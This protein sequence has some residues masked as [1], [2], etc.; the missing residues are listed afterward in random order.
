VSKN[1]TLAI[2]E[3]VLDE[4]RLFAAKRNTTVNGLVRDYLEGI[5]KQED[6]VTRARRRLLELSEQ[7][8]L[9][10]GEVTWKR[11]DLYDR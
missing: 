2:D 5:A 7:S 1:I 10:V 6:R 3:A 11:S 4:V 9:E 8:T